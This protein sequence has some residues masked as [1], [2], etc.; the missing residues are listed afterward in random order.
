MHHW[1]TIYVPYLSYAL[2]LCSALRKESIKDNRLKVGDQNIKYPEL[3]PDCILYHFYGYGMG[4][5]LF[6]SYVGAE[7]RP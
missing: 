2:Y 3:A 6:E 4:R 1:G 7:E 5:L